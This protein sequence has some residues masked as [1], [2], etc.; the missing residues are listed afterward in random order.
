MS[1]FPLFSE[2]VCHE[3]E[4]VTDFSFGAPKLLWMVT[5]A[6]KLN[7]TYS[8]EDEAMTNLDSILKSRDI[9][10]LT[11]VRIVKTMCFSGVMNGCESWLNA[12]ELMLLDCGT[13]EDS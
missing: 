9:I 3:V 5:V 11:K 1:L 7:D 4:T 6:T 8:L 13:G 10:L 2:S 12:E